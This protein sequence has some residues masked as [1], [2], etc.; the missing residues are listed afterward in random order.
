MINTC[1]DNYLVIILEGTG[2]FKIIITLYL[3][4][5]KCN[6][7]MIL[8]TVLSNKTFLVQSIANYSDFHNKQLSSQSRTSIKTKYYGSRA[9]SNQRVKQTTPQ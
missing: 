2:I 8:M 6:K 7:K 1:F 3:H 9:S 5:R 4:W